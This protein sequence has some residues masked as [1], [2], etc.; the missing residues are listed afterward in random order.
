MN[1]IN[2]ESLTKSLEPTNQIIKRKISIS[3]QGW[4]HVPDEETGSRAAKEAG[5]QAFVQLE[6]AR[7]VGDDHDQDRCD[8]PE[9]E[10][11]F[12]RGDQPQS[13]VQ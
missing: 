1:R 7:H 13:G 2:Q 4:G 11:V 3:F 5:Q 9:R 6:L 8:T 12:R 10:A